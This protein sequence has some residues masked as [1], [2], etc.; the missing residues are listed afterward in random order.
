M[1]VNSFEAAT[2]ERYVYAL[3]IIRPYLATR[4][5]Q[6]EF[7][8]AANTLGLADDDYYGVFSYSEGA[9]SNESLMFKPYAYI[10]E[11]ASW[12]FTINDVDTY[13]IVPKYENELDAI[14]EALNQQKYDK[15]VALI[16]SLQEAHTAAQQNDL[17]LPNVLC[18][19]VIT[20][21]VGQKSP[22]VIKANDGLTASRRALNYVVYNFDS[23][24]TGKMDIAGLLIEINY[25]TYSKDLGRSLVEVILTYKN[26]NLETFYSC[27]IDVTDEYPFVDFPLRNFVPKAA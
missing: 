11:K 15:T 7:D 5:L 2:N 6:K 14:I 13:M 8:A 26:Q 12:V 23:L 21:P 9:S 24:I 18:N 25:Q 1:G 10:A 27:G 4:D 3:G 16:G 22:I 19:H 17:L 20:Q